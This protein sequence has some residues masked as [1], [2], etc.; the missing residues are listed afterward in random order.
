[1]GATMA[2]PCVD[3]KDQCKLSVNFG[4]NEAF[5][6]PN[7]SLKADVLKYASVDLHA[8]RRINYKGDCGSKSTIHVSKLRL[9]SSA[10][11]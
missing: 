10:G 7:L 9:I 5:F 11:T 3:C 8:D 2:L 6:W 1:M 4:T